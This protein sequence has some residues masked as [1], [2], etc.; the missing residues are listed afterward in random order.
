MKS[1]HVF[2]Y[3]DLK[4]CLSVLNIVLIIEIIKRR[5]YLICIDHF[6]SNISYLVDLKKY[7]F[8]CGK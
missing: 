4:C 2:T 1:T 3:Y 5:Y 8:I 7:A 6:V